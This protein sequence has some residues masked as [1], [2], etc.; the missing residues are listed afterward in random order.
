MS[1]DASLDGTLFGPDQPCF[2]CGPDHPI[3]FRLRFEKDG[4]W[5][6]TRLVPGERYQG[7]PGIMHGGLVTTLADEI[8][9]WAIIGQLGKFGFTTRLDV[10][11]HRAVRI[12]TEVVGRSRIVNDLRR[13]ADVEVVLNQGDD[14]C[15]RGQLRFAIFDEKG[16]ERVLGRPLGADWSR[17]GR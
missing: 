4:E 7:P 9:A 10:T 8:G 14:V 15:V 1:G 12:G 2:G 5:M 17:F 16:A 13:L 3:G 11:L 6:V